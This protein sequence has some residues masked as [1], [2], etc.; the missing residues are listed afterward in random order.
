MAKACGFYDP[1]QIFLGFSNDRIKPAKTPTIFV[2]E[3][4]PVG[5]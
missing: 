5:K 2:R 3:V 4:S 1:N